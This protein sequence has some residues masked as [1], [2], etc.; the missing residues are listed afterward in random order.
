MQILIAIFALLTFKRL[1]SEGVD[2]TKDIG[3]VGASLYKEV[4]DLVVSEE[5][6]A[7][8]K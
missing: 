6:K 5:P 3:D 8:G 7:K 1:K 2:V 4:R